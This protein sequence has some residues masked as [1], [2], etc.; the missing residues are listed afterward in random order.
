MKENFTD[1]R[2]KDAAMMVMNAIRNLDGTIT[3]EQRDTLYGVMQ[4]VVWGKPH[5]QT[6][7][8]IL[9]HFDDVGL[10]CEDKEIAPFVGQLMNVV[11]DLKP[12]DR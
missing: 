9:M 2:I 10:D 11:L 6:C 3:T 1:P 8:E 7:S 4:F 5:P 12:N